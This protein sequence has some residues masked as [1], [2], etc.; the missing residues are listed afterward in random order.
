[1]LYNH[2]SP[3]ASRYY[4]DGIQEF[5][6]AVTHI[7]VILGYL[8]EFGNDLL[9]DEYKWFKFMELKFFVITQ[10]SFNINLDCIKYITYFRLIVELFPI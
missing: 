5:A 7:R 6:A 8:V 10:Y 9:E 2:A 1:M 4:L 3:F